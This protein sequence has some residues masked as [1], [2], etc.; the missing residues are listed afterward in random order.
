VK[1]EENMK[2]INAS[3]TCHMLKKVDNEMLQNHFICGK[4]LWS[5]LVRKSLRIW[6]RFS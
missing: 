1:R 3:R 2:S 5:E 6:W 4:L